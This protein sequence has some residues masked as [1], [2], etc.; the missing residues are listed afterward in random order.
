MLA[1]LRAERVA[2]EMKLK[3]RYV[4]AGDE[5]RLLTEVAAGRPDLILRV[6]FPR[7]DKVGREEE[8][9]DVPL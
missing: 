4:G 5:Y 8:W 2:K 9:L 6:D 3:A 7:P 1:L